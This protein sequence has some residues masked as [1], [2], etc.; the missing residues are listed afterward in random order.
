MCEFGFRVSN[1][2]ENTI[3]FWSEPDLHI[4]R[5]DRKNRSNMHSDKNLKFDIIIN[6]FITNGTN[7]ILYKKSDENFS[8][9]MLVEVLSRKFQ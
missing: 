7:N 6:I 5:L 1:L 4:Y 2:V 3:E 8:Y 9:K